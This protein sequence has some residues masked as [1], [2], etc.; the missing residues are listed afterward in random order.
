[1]ADADGFDFPIVHSLQGGPSADGDAL[2]VEA[3]AFDGSVLRFA[4]PVDNIPHLVA[5]LLIW[6]GKI[7]AMQPGSDA[8]EPARSMP[9]P[10]SSIAIGEPNGEEGYLGIAVGRAELV[11]SL[12]VSAPT[13]V[14][15]SLLV[16]GLRPTSSPS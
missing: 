15:Q 16:A 5:F 1:M 11:F 10:A 9:I 3:T 12:P 8:T 6:A 13:P 2:L 14:G 4:L 7:S